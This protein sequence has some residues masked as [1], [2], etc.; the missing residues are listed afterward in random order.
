MALV[1]W[2]G[3]DDDIR[4]L[5]ASTYGRSQSVQAMVDGHQD[6]LD[7]ITELAGNETSSIDIEEASGRLW[8]WV[9]LSRPSCKRA[10]VRMVSFMS[11]RPLTTTANIVA[12]DVYESQLA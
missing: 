9:S 1:D 8:E 11:E 2:L 7:M 10:R 12:A 3:L 6:A 4:G 5:V